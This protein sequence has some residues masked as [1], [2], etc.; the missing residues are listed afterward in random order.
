MPITKKNLESSFFPQDLASSCIEHFSR[1]S[2][3][4]GG[5]DRRLDLT[6]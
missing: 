2:V 4:R 1:F 5:P 3:F 6:R